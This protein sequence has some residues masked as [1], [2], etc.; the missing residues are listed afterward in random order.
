MNISAKPWKKNKP[1]KRILAIRLQAIGDTVITLPYLQYLKNHLPNDTI[2]DLFT[3]EE[4]NHIPKQIH[5]FNKIYSIG[6]GRS[7][8]KQLFYTAL[9][10]PKLLL[11]RYD[12]VLDLQNNEVSN[13][14]RKSLFPKA[15][16]SFDRFSPLSAGDRTRLTIEAAGLGPCGI[17]S[18]F[19]LEKDEEEV[20]FL[21]KNGWDKSNDLIVL[22]PAGAFENRNWPIDNYISFAHLWLNQFPQTQFLITGTNFI[23]KKAAYLKEKLGNHLINLAGTSSATQ[24]FSILQRARLVL[25]EDSGLM[26]MA[27]ISGI[28]TLAIFGSTRSDWARPLGENTFFLDSSELECGNCMK[29]ICKYGDNHCMSRITPAVVFEEAVKLVCK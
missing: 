9:L 6:G 1:P 15:W 17:D 4:T 8:K 20:D 13:L 24:A 22:N 27:W 26:H 29:A 19:I 16:S 21:K 28:P 23:E 11:N 18:N 10:L 2:L 12:I 7:L 5:L 3:R 14:V 25:S